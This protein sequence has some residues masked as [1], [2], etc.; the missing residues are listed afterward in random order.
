MQWLQDPKQ[1]NA[2]NI[3][4][5]R[6]EDN[7]RFANKKKEYLNLILMTLKLTVR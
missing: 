2:N 1:S 7:K 5:V 6:H 3:N 4:N